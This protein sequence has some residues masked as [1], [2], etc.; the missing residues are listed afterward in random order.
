MCAG[1]A[2]KDKRQELDCCD[3]DDC[4][5]I[6]G[7]TR[8]FPLGRNGNMVLCKKCFESVMAHHRRCNREGFTDY[9][10]WDSF[11]E[12]KLYSIPARNTP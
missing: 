6:H 12:G 4:R 8:S 3:G 2:W 10:I 5:G 11:T 1:K 7:E 9:P